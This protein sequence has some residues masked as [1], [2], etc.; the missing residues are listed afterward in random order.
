MPRH[1]LSGCFR[2]LLRCIEDYGSEWAP[3]GSEGPR[4]V[5]HCIHCVGQCA[6]VTTDCELRVW[7]ESTCPYKDAHMKRF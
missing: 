2:G 4:K 5:G 3:I 7:Q 1:E 6:G